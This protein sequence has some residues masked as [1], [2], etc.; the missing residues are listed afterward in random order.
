MVRN[1]VF[2][3]HYGLLKLI[4][5]ENLTKRTGARRMRVVVGRRYVTAEAGAIGAPLPL[6]VMRQSDCVRSASRPRCI[7]PRPCCMVLKL[8]SAR[9]ARLAGGDE[10]ARPELAEIAFVAAV[11]VVHLGSSGY[12]FSLQTPLIKGDLR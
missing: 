10:W 3:A 11:G 2:L 5:T 7:A 1:V 9:V 4:G 6:V 12:F 8:A